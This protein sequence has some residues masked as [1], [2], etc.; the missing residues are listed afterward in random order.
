MFKRHVLASVVA[1]TL[2]GMAYAAEEPW[3]WVR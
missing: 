2:V 3:I 1:Y